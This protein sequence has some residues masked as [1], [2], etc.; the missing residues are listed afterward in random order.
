MQYLKAKTNHEPGAISDDLVF[1]RDD[2]V[3]KVYVSSPKP[4]YED[5]KV[6]I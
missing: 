4:K 1:R 2:I 6:N 5:T 3:G